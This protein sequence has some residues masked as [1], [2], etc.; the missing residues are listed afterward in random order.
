MNI[1]DALEMAKARI[2]QLR[3]LK[4]GDDD[5]VFFDER[6]IV[7]EYGW[8]FF[9]NSRRFLASGSIFDMIIGSGPVLVNKLN[10]DVFVMGSAYNVA[11]YI[12]QY[13]TDNHI[14]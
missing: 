8:I 14:K 2:N 13:E 1:E 12:S 6:T 5:T 7:K 10:G 9:Y 3:G 4:E 11:H